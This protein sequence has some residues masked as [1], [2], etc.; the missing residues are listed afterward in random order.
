MLIGFSGF[1][2]MARHTWC[3]DPEVRMILRLLV[4]EFGIEGQ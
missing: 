2:F 1:L 4:C 3:P